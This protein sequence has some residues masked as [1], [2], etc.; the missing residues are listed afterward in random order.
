MNKSVSIAGAKATLSECIRNV[1][2]GSPM[3]IT[4]HGKPVAALVRASDF[5]HLERLRKAGPEGGLASLAGGWEG[6][7]ELRRILN[8]S[9]RIGQ[10]KIPP[11][12]Q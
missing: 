10:R 4:R 2:A 9:P 12:D 8:E 1:E 5:D 11:F 3:L 7:D 6:S